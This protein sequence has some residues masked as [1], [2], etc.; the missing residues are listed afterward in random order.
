[1]A[2]WLDRAVS[3]LEAALGVPPANLLALGAAATGALVLATIAYLWLTSHRERGVVLHYERLKRLRVA[4]AAAR[5][6]PS[7]PAILTQA[8]SAIDALPAAPMVVPAATD[9]PKRS[10]LPVLIRS[11]R[12]GQRCRWRRDTV[13]SETRLVRWVCVECGADSYALQG[14]IPRECKRALRNPTL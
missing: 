13:R 14:R 12:R 7:C 2:G 5:T 1:M 6:S 8:R 4:P 9:R 10:T 3:R 11:L